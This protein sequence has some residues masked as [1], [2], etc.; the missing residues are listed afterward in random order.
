[1][2]ITEIE[3]ALNELIIEAANSGGCLWIVDKRQNNFAFRVCEPVKLRAYIP[4]NKES[5]EK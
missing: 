3:K 4:S 1:M 2:E 5:E